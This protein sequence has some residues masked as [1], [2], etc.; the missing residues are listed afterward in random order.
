M[1]SALIRLGRLMELQGIA[2]SR[3]DA[4]TGKE[5]K[6]RSKATGGGGAAASPAEAGTSPE[7][8]GA[9]RY[10][11]ATV[12]QIE[13]EDLS[14]VF[15][16]TGFKGE[17]TLD[18]VERVV[19]A[20]PGLQLSFD[21]ADMTATIQS[22]DQLVFEKR[23]KDSTSV[24][25]DADVAQGNGGFAL[26]GDVTDS[27]DYHLWA[28]A[29]IMGTP[30]QERPMHCRSAYD[31]TQL[32]YL[33]RV[34]KVQP[35]PHG[36]CAAA[37]QRCGK[38]KLLERVFMMQMCDALQLVGPSEDAS[39][40]AIDEALR[41]LDEELSSPSAAAVAFKSVMDAAPVKSEAI[42]KA[43]FAVLR[44]A[45]SGA[46]SGPAPAPAPASAPAPPPPPTSTVE[47][48]YRSLFDGLPPGV[49]GSSKSLV[50]QV[51]APNKKEFGNI[52][53]VSAGAYD[54]VLRDWIAARMPDIGNA[55]P[56]TPFDAID[57]MLQAVVAFATDPIGA[58][59]AA[60]QTGGAGAATGGGRGGDGGLS[61]ALDQTTLP[62]L[63]SDTGYDTLAPCVPGM[64][65]ITQAD[66]LVGKTDLLDSAMSTKGSAGVWQCANLGVW[67]KEVN[68]DTGESETLRVP[69]HLLNWAI[70]QDIPKE[71]GQGGSERAVAVRK[72]HSAKACVV[73][74]VGAMIEK[75]SHGGEAH[76]SLRPPPT[77]IEQMLKGMLLGERPKYIRANTTTTYHDN[78]PHL[79]VPKSVANRPRSTF[80]F[81]EWYYACGM[82][83][84]C[85]RSLTMANKALTNWCKAVDALSDVG[86]LQW[87]EDC[88]EY[89]EAHN[90]DSQRR[91]NDQ[92]FI[93]LF[94]AGV[95]KLDRLNQVWHMQNEPG[96]RPRLYSV[97]ED[98]S[99]VSKVIQECIKLDLIELV[100]N[101]KKRSEVILSQIP[102]LF[103]RDGNGGYVSET[104]ASPRPRSALR[105]PTPAAGPL[106]QTGGLLQLQRPPPTPTDHSD[107]RNF[108]AGSD[109]HDG[110]RHDGSRPGSA[111]R[112]G[113]TDIDL[114]AAPRKAGLLQSTELL[115]TQEIREREIVPVFAS[116]QT[117]QGKCV[118]FYMNAVGCDR[119]NCVFCKRSLVAMQT[120]DPADTSAALRRAAGSANA[121]SRPGTPGRDDARRGRSGSHDRSASAGRGD[122]RDRS[123]SRDRN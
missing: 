109:G 73:D 84:N 17:W 56:A 110:R 54:Q 113:S 118:N 34:G 51:I 39:S 79:C 3:A 10:G 62:A 65:P 75:A 47:S 66:A 77:V 93:D 68:V 31:V 122:G 27:L 104:E 13:T 123:R 81:F 87:K 12:V 121:R 94:L 85:G 95:I 49:A 120:A 64:L 61:R 60:G 76:G 24:L 19:Q 26:W 32:R 1:A 5:G 101:P 50:L 41:E 6:R 69:D 21:A 7:V 36:A 111:T 108:G 35:A 23:T 91:F 38:V 15:D 97:F 117:L 40:S 9:R 78:G 67:K 82:Y 8:F 114:P 43:C 90:A 29:L 116:D 92:Q 30:Y 25:V 88:E 100:E 74:A 58:S 37:V 44:T 59:G 102:I 42:T 45:K 112:P 103:S 4:A 11:G 33:R 96:P 2:S 99:P 70:T 48:V 18:E 22:L 72:L 89:L 14:D 28:L 106:T 107:R 86:M 105:I 57:T 46:G 63:K 55:M 119:P 115:S 53:V 71:S 20:L 98:K 52:A 80:E 16:P 83:A